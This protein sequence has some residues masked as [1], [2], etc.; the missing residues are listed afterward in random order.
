MFAIVLYKSCPVRP[1]GFAVL[2]VGT[3]MPA[4][5]PLLPTAQNR[6]FRSN[7]LQNRRS[8]SPGGPDGFWTGLLTPKTASGRASWRPRR[9]LDGPPGAQA[10][11]WTGLL[12]PKT[13]SGFWTGLLTPETASGRAS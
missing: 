8:W 2:R 12:T 11:L 6:R 7:G 3:P 10:G 9:P 4:G 5:T 1:G 13:A